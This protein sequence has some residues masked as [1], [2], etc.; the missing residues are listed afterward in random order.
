MNKYVKEFLHR[1]LI[2]S[3]FGPVVLGIIYLIVNA[4]GAKVELGA[5]DVFKAIMSTY[6][7]AFVHAGASV[8]PTIDHWSKVKAMFFQ[9][10]SIYTVYLV[11]YLI[12]SWIPFSLLAIGLYTGCFVLAF[13]AIWIVAYVTSNKAAKRMNE[14][15]KEINK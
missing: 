6:V 15:L 5:W 13:V 9:G 14:K 3:G 7:M 2:F 8:F 4:S 12:N 10:L 1:G 11:G